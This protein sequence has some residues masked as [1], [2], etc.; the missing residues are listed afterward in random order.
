MEE[1]DEEGKEKDEESVPVTTTNAPDAQLTL[2]VKKRKYPV[3]L[4]HVKGVSE[5]LRRVFKSYNIPTYFKPSNTHTQATSG[6]YQ[7]QVG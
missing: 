5:Q 7:E 4:P 6:M 3:V 2:E 1:N